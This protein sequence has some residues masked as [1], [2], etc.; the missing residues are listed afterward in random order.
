MGLTPYAISI[1]ARFSFL[2]RLHD[3][4]VQQNE[5]ENSDRT[6][7]HSLD[8]VLRGDKLSDRG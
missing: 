7:V 3:L 5:P 6:S 4:T 1:Q 8:W 2:Y